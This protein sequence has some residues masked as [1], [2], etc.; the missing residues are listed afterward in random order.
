MCCG[1]A[2]WQPAEEEIRS[3]RAAGFIIEEAA[4]DELTEESGTWRVVMRD[5]VGLSFAFRAGER[6]LRRIFGRK[7][8]AARG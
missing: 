8:A 1:P 5:P 7:L 4:P 3:W 2:L 6:L